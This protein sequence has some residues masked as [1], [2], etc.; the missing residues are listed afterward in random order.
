MKVRY[1]LSLLI[2]GLMLVGCL[3]ITQSYALWIITEEQTN[4]NEM[5]VGCFSIGFSEQSESIKL[6]NTYPVNDSIGLSTNPYTFTITNTCTINNN[7]VLTLNTLSTNTLDAS[8]IKY[9]LYKSS[10]EKPNVGSKLSRINTDLENLMVENLGT[11]YILD[12]GV[13]S[14]GTKVDGVVNNGEE[15]TYNLYLWID[16]IA[17]NEV[18]GQTFEAS[19]NVINAATESND[20]GEVY[21]SAVAKCGAE[22]K[23]AVTCMKENAN[24]DTIN[25]A[26]DGK[27]SLGEEL[28]TD[29]N[30]LRYIGSNPNNYVS[31]NGEKWRIIGV[32]NNL[33]SEQE[34][35]SEITGSHLKIIRQDG[36][37]GQKDFGNYS[38][39]YGKE[40]IEN[41][42]V[43]SSLKNMLNGIYYESGIGDCYTAQ[44]EIGNKNTCN[45]SGS[46]TDLPK[47]IDLN[48]REMIDNEIIWSLGGYNSV[49]INSKNIYI[50]ERGT[51]VYN[52][53]YPN[54]WTKENDSNYHNGIGLI[55]PSDYGYAVGGN[56]RKTCL[57]LNIYDYYTE[58][59]SLN[60]WLKPNKDYQWLLTSNSSHSGRSYNIFSSGYVSHTGSIDYAFG[61]WPT[62]Y[63]KSN[64][65]IINGNGTIDNPFILE[66]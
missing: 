49:G 18:E 66:S 28:G 63:L 37:A 60:D 53:E 54:E 43:K 44:N 48:F 47:G 10:E 32:M 7:Y 6:D 62:L 55:Y 3:Y 40:V 20:I 41:N 29:D 2:I 8:K 21:G 26:Y 58:S 35:G 61:V 25:L 4:E 9:A 36:I 1:K 19:I 33:R 13:L 64:V 15:V 11:S 39:D 59:C 12:T 50:N 22:G 24:L 65:K 51:A 23:D 31:F 57:N 14:G 30:N 17:G 45:F 46:E 27:E 16:D 42:W 5:D 56:V 38:W 34:D 52:Q